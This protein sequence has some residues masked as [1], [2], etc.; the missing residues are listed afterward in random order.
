MKHEYLNGKIMSPKVS[1][2][3]LD[4]SC[5]ESFHILNYL[6]TQSIPRDQYE[7]IWVEYYSRVPDEQKEMLKK[8]LQ[9]DK[10]PILDQWI[11]MEM[12]QNICYHKHLMYNIG[13]ALSHGEIV[14]IGD[15]DAIVSSTFIESIIREFEKDSNIVLHMDEF[16]NIRQDFHPFNYP[17]INEILTEGCLNNDNGKT[18]GILDN[19]DPIHTRNYGACMCA[20]KSDLIA[21]GGADEHLDY[22]GHVCGPYEMSFR[23]QNFGKRE[24]WH[25]NEFLY[26]AWHPGESGD[27]NF[28]GPHDGKLVSTT[29]LNILRFGN[30][31]PLVQNQAIKSLR[32]GCEPKE[33][34]QYNKLIDSSYFKCFSADELA[35]LG[36]LQIW[37]HHQLITEYKKF[38]IVSFK[39]N[40]YGI[41]AF[42]NNPDLNKEEDEHPLIVTAASIENVK[43]KIDQFEVKYFEP[44]PLEKYKSFTILR[45]GNSLYAIPDS[46]GKIDIFDTGLRQNLLLSAKDI[47]TLK[48]II[49]TGEKPHYDPVIIESYRNYNI[50]KYLK[51]VFAVRHDSGKVEF[52]VS[53]EGI[54]PEVLS[55]STVEDVK[56]L[57]DKDLECNFNPTVIE[58]YRNYNIIKYLKKVFAVP[59]SLGKVEFSLSMEGIPPEVLSASTAEDV[60]I[61]IDQYIN[62]LNDRPALLDS[63]RD[64]NL[65]KYLNKVFAV[66]QSLGKVEFSLSMEG[67]PPEVLSA[68]TLEDVKLLIYSDYPVILDSYRSYNLIKYLNKVFAV[69]QSLATVEFSVTMENLPPEILSSYTLE[70]TKTLINQHLKILEAE[71]EQ[72]AEEKSSNASTGLLVKNVK[73]FYKYKGYNISL[74][75]DKYYAVPQTVG[76]IDFSS[77]KQLS[78]PEIIYSDNLKDLNV[79]ID[80]LCAATAVEYAGWLPSFK[81][82]GDCGNHPQFM[83]TDLPP[84]GYRFTFSLPTENSL[85][86]EDDFKKRL[87]SRIDLLARETQIN[88]AISKFIISALLRGCKLRAIVEFL[89][90]RG[91]RD[92]LLLK[93]KQN[94]VF[95][96]SVPYTLNQHPWIIEI[97]D[98]ISMLFPFFHNGDTKSLDFHKSPYFRVFK[99]L[100]ESG[101]CRGIVTHIK[102]TA[103]N[104]PKLF[105]SDKLR[106]KTI[107]VPFGIKLPLHSSNM[108]IENRPIRFLFN[109]SWH[110]NPDSFIFRGGLDVLRA[111]ERLRQNHPNIHL[112]IRSAI[113][114][115]NPIYLAIIRRCQIKIIDHFLPKQEW[116][117][118]L[119]RSDIYLLPSARIHIVSILQAM[120]YGLGVV[121]SDGWGIEEYVEHGR[122]GMI[123]PG[124]YGKVTWMDNENGILRENYKEMLKEEPKIL[125]G[126]VENVS[127]LLTDRVL[128]RKIR[129]QARKDIE[130]K[131]NITN[132]N[133][134]LKMAFDKALKK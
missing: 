132:W 58:S 19:I 39:N 68:S 18:T 124:R 85:S 1:L 15:S 52:S 29:A 4:W 63:Y 128:L 103:D 25:H 106:N 70:D 2:I 89:K 88:I 82:F 40:F 49:D 125:D 44:T 105:K 111:F 118:L 80:R 22:L 30:V 37:H 72:A 28:V 6:K 73:F 120:S 60:K 114:K 27:S 7:I 117:A 21:I 96:T 126:I 61:L 34:K 122:N 36:N 107:H 116:D 95:L 127:N 12:P 134:G 32:L 64:Y 81:K 46:F 115:L 93:R 35:R 78:H 53:M 66:P 74:Y 130:E 94:L 112:T 43:E 23:L 101:Q 42:L 113:P 109:N 20:K 67:V 45:F 26:H 57:V 104:I 5:R 77:E 108:N 11:V 69:P 55:A 99:T 87:F 38:N 50:I 119:R 16:R 75:K 47:K 14:M 97:E 83:H 90:S 86:N 8:S 123:V 129:T 9:E 121:T 41:P 100:L 131:Y 56:I 10:Y 92:Q 13:I 110:Q 102:S 59:Q 79:I 51:K 3:L 76:A 48:S 31:L 91:R 54:P 62:N 84:E 71:L 24:I 17:T 98:S 133:L 33:G 65:I